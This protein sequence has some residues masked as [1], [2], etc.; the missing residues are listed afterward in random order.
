MGDETSLW[1]EV[2]DQ[3][4]AYTDHEQSS[5][6]GSQTEVQGRFTGQGSISLL[7]AKGEVGGKHAWARGGASS[8]SRSSNPKT[9]AITALREAQTA[10]IIDDFHYLDREVQGSVV[11]GLKALIFEGLPVVILAIPHRRY[12]AVRVEREMTG[13]VENIQVPS[14][15]LD[16]LLEIPHAGFPCLRLDVEQGIQNRFAE[17]AL[18]S[19]HLMQEFCRELCRY[20]G[21]EQ[22]CPQDRGFSDDTILQNLFECV[23]AGT[24]KTMFEK[25]KR[26]PRQ[27]SDR[28]QRSLKDGTNT[29]I[30]GTV[31]QGLAAMKPGIQTVE[32]ETLREAIRDIVSGTPPQ[33]HD[34]SRV[35]EH[36][37]NISANDESST[38][39][40]DWEKEERLLHVT[41]PFFAYYLRWGNLGTTT[42]SEPYK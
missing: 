25:L 9:T 8:G 7:K 39:V 23:A 6:K 37:A 26:G 38:P 32:Y 36:M 5:N 29:D 12:D 34:I 13:R 42:N 3:L 30:Y 21:V 10:V 14:W 27:R 41:D 2:N 15:E 19:P 20:L 28:I 17:E 4:E 1:S 35:L 22:T 40:I 33:A 18:G 24:G 31:L 11:R 16:E